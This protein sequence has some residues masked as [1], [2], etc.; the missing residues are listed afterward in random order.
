MADHYRSHVEQATGKSLESVLKDLD[1]PDATP[2]PTDPVKKE[3]P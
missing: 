2:P 1:A 3:S